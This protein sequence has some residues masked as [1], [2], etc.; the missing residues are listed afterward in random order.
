MPQSLSQIYLHIVFST[1]KRDPFISAKIES[2]LYTYIGGTIK[3]LNALPI[4]ISGTEDHI[5]ILTSFPRTISVA[6]FIKKIK[7][8]SSHW[9]KDKG[10]EFQH[11]AWQDG[12]GVFSISPSN[13]Q[14]VIDYIVNQKEHHKKQTF[15]GELIRFLNKYEIKYDEQYLW[16]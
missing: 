1:K 4:M 6:D 2:E 10:N 9:I 13:K 14:A 12:Y 7:T 16:D 15:Q 11:F 3:N 8:G 5:H